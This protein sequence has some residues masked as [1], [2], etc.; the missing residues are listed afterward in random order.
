MYILNGV[1]NIQIWSKYYITFINKFVDK[2][3]TLIYQ[4]IKYDPDRY[5]KAARANCI[6]K[7]ILYSSFL[8]FYF[9]PVTF[10]FHMT[11]RKVG[12]AT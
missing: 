12:L 7:K 9:V 6:D 3:F 2:A 5:I 11:A 8:Y 10:D 1:N 4:L